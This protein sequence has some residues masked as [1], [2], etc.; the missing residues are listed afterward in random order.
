MTFYINGYYGDKTHNPEIINVNSFSYVSSN[1]IQNRIFFLIF[2]NS[3]IF[4]FLNKLVFFPAFKITSCMSWYC[5]VMN[6][7]YQC[8]NLKN[9]INI[10]L[11]MNY[12]FYLT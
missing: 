11:L 4:K 10:C 6:V 7:M 1:T 5:G 8:L 9:F 3:M 12:K 2:Y